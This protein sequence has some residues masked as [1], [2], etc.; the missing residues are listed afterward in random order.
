MKIAMAQ[1]DILSGG[2]KENTK[3]MVDFIVQAKERGC[4]LVVFP[5]MSDTGYDMPVILDTA[6]TWDNGPVVKLRETAQK[7]Q[8]NVIAGVSRRTSVGVYNGVVVIDRNGGIVHGYHKTHLITA[9]P[10]LEHRF[11]QAGEALGFFELEGV[12]IGV[13]TCYEIRFPEIARTLAL[14]GTELL[15]IPAAWPMVRLPHWQGLAVARAIENQVYVAAVN[16]IGNGTGLRF[17]GTSLLV[18]PYGEV[19]TSG[20][21]IHEDLLVGKI[22][23]DR[24]N[25]VREQIKVHQD[26]RPE[27]YDLGP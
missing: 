27:L 20:T 16:R 6:S 2:V 25:A 23:R 4:D 24:I 10:M 9:E 11:L 19:I 13:M 14:K 7:L 3:K 12:K 15:V 8:I 1:M 18:G 5:E 21:Q 26:R 17:A 22:E